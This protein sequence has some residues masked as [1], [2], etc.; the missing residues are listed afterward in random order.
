MAKKKRGTKAKKKGAEPAPGGTPENAATRARTNDDVA[1]R[2]AAT[3][4]PSVGGSAIFQRAP[5]TAEE[6]EACRP[7][8]ISPEEVLE[9]D[10]ATWYEK[11]YRG[12]DVPQ[13]TLRAVAMGSFLGFFLAFTNLYV[14]L[15]TGWGLGV[16]ITACILSF[17]M[18]SGLVK[19][20]LAKTPLTILETN[21]MQSTASSAGY[22]TVGTSVSAIAALLILSID[23]AHPRGEHL[24]W[25]VL[26]GWTLFLAALGTLM[27]I[28][29]KR[30]MINQERLKFPSGTAAAV[31]LQSLYSQG[32]EAIKKA[33][34]LLYAALFGALFPFLIELKIRTTTAEDGT[35]ERSPILPSDL[36]IFDWLPAPGTHVED[37]RTVPYLPSDWTMVWDM[38]P[39]LIA[40]GALVGL[41]IAT[42]MLISGVVLVYGLGG[43]AIDDLWT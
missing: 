6:L 34:A 9:M 32:S 15:K 3:R 26:G 16:A 1:P 38:N 24:S 35:T 7:L 20:K 19:L 43:F 11:V 31:T 27:A 13:L 10:E 18:S 22:S 17:A 29:M 25:P 2:S 42:Y 39:V 33:R 28:P 40:A 37:G 30:N 21:C 12:D 23:E 4:P 41:R 8:S 5:E 14:G 36:K